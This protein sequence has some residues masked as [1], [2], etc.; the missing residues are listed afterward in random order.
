MSRAAHSVAM[1]AE[2]DRLAR[3]HLLRADRQEDICFAL[4]HVSKGQTRTTALIERLLLPRRGERKVHGNAS[5]EP[6]FLE[7]AMAKAASSCAGL[8]LLHS[9]PLGHG[10][11]GLSR[12]DVIAEQSNA[13]AVFG[14]TGQPFVGLTLA[15][16]GAWSARFWERTAPRTYPG[17]WCATVRVV[18]DR[19]AVTFMNKLAPPP[20]STESQIRTV[21][22][23]GEE[24]QAHLVR[25]RAGVIGAGSVGGMIAESLARTGFEDLVLIDFDIVKE[26]NLDRLNYATQRDVGHLK[27][28]VLAD[29]LRPRATAASFKVCPV[30]AAVYEEEAYR[31]ALDCDLLFSCVDRPWGRYA[32]NLIAYSHLIPVIDGG[33]R[34][35]ANRF[36]KL[37]AADWRAHTATIGRPCLQCLDQYDPG[38]VQLEREGMLDDPK[39]I[40][41]LPKDHPLKA[42]QN[43]F[44]FSMSCASFQTLQMLALV[45]APLDQP[46]PGSQMYHFVGGFM[47]KPTFGSCNPECLFPAVTALGDTSGISPTGVRPAA[48]P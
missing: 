8:A 11:Q 35:R 20:P 33:I 46:N 41:A 5:F 17:A 40:E 48:E 47:E 16:D 37:A 25:L 31:A 32:L 13:G 22:A 4:W 14:A 23:W 42:R 18:G 39:Y 45:L 15:A 2:V 12:D 24:S 19:L 36:G 28:D 27:V 1:T 9:H 26:H 3:K 30:A 21:S 43:V 29:Y 10:W 6:I 34:A 44:A 38:H 7:R